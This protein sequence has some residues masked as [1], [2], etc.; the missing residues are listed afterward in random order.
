M[1][2]NPTQL[3]ARRPA[4][5]HLLDATGALALAVDQLKK[6]GLPIMARM[7][8]AERSELDRMADLLDPAAAEPPEPESYCRCP[9]PMCP[10]HGD[11]PGV[12]T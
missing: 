12:P 1:Q 4:Y 8:D 3:A 5:Y 2:N 10:V 6:A 9:G 7:V 11:N